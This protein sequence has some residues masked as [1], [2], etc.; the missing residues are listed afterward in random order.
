MCG[1]SDWL[2]PDE[3][4]V[5]RAHRQHVALQRHGDE[6]AVVVDKRNGERL[7]EG[8]LPGRRSIGDAQRHE[9]VAVGDEQQVGTGRRRQR[10]RGRRDPEALAAR[11][12]VGDDAVSLDREKRTGAV[13]GRRDARRELRIEGK[14]PLE[15]QR[16]ERE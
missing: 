13:E 8:P 1:R 5:R 12:V 7:G 11:E 9:M 16:K 14:R 3:R 4:A 10:R 15:L 2:P 6:P